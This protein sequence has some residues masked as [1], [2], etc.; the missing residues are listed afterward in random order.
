MENFLKC[1]FCGRKK[2]EITFLISGINGHICNFCIEKTYS[3][4]HKKFSTEKKDFE[5][6]IYN[7]KNQK[8]QIKKPKEIKDFLDK[9]IIGQNEAKKIISVAVYNHYKRIQY[10]KNKNK[11]D[12]EIE[13]SNILLIGNT[14]TGKTLLA[15]SI[16]KLL[17]V[18]FTIADATTLTEAGYVGED[19]ESILTRLL[20]SVNYDIN[21]AEKGIVFIDEIDKISRKK[22]NPSITRDVSGEG[23]QQSLLKLL[24]GTIINV[25]PQGGRKHPDQKMIQ[26][27]TEN[28]LFIAGGTF[29][30]IEKII[31]DRINQFSIGFIIK[32]RKKEKK[33]FLKNII[34]N[35]LRKFGLIPEL[36]GR[37]PIITYL[38]PLNK[39]TLKKILIE[40]KNALIKQYKKL[41]NMDK[42]SMN[43]T[44]EALDII[45]DK[46][47][48]LGLGARGL[49]TFCEKIFV[50]YIFEMKESNKI[51]NI[52]KNM[53]IKKLFYS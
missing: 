14:G 52:D 3:I 46:T 49:R 2:D 24:E 43:I 7:V 26:I 34:A 40:P 31:Y 39:I 51:L 50:D 8:I 13:K 48:Q 20:Q 15:K 10:E 33:N 32:K 42:I 18:P 4:I 38:D 35:D 27:N 37:F 17:K 12:I 36:I 1:N 41:F 28:I 53:V 21:H 29:D 19:V 25:P 11:D 47:I 5:E 30:G 23:V 9:Y 6:K 16:S 45:V 22:N 44:D